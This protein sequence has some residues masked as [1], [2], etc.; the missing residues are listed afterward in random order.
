MIIG[1]PE[2]LLRARLDPKTL[3]LWIEEQWLLPVTSAAGLAFSELDLARAGLIHQLINDLGVNDDG[4]GIILNL[5][6]QMHTVRKVLA[7]ALEL[8]A[9]KRDT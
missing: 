2:F 3:E 4:V 5:L 7:E 8:I 6:D 9:V 1:R